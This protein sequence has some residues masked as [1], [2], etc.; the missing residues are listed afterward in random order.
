M[1]STEIPLAVNIVLLHLHVFDPNRNE[2]R[3]SVAVVTGRF[4]SQQLMKSH[5]HFLTVVES[6]IS[7]YCSSSSNNTAGGPE[8]FGDTTAT[9][10]VWVA[11]SCYRITPRGRP[12]VWD[13]EA[14]LS[15]LPIA[16]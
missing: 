9:A 7:Q 11:L 6:S 12:F 2:S 15:R 5:F 14:K 13:A 3:N 8:V 16:K 4:R 10:A 1:S